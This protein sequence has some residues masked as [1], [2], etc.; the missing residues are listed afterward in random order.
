MIGLVSSSN[1]LSNSS[2]SLL[3][4]SVRNVSEWSVTSRGGDENFKFTRFSNSSFE[5]LGVSAIASSVT[6]P[7]YRY[8]DMDWGSVGSS[9]PYFQRKTT[10]F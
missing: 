3:A 6:I 9:S 5:S 2:A 8:N 10:G 1:A 7:Y 4:P